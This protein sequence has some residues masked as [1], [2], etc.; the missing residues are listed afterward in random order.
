MRLREGGSQTDLDIVSLFDLKNWLKRQLYSPL[1]F[2]MMLLMKT[3]KRELTIIT[4]ILIALVVGACRSAP[5]TP[6]TVPTLT[7]INPTSTALPI[8]SATT[9]P[10]ATDTATPTSSLPISS[11][12]DG[13]RMAYIFD[14]NLYFQD[15]SKPPVQL[16]DSRE[17]RQPI[18]FSEDG[19]RVFFTRGRGEIYSI[20][21]DGSQEQALVTNDVL[22]TFGADYYDETTTP[23]DPVL[24]P[25]THLLLFRTCSVSVQSTILHHDDVF[26][27]DADTNKVK[28]IFPREQGGRFYVS[29]DGSMIAIDKLNSIDILGIDGRVIRS[30]VATYPQSEL[31]SMGARVYWVSDSK[32][33]I[34]LLPSKTFVDTFP[35]PTYTVWR[36]S[37][38]THTSVQIQLDPTPMNLGEIWVSPDGNWIAYF[39]FFEGFFLGNLQDGSTQ[40]YPQAHRYGNPLGWS[41]D[42]VHFIYEMPDP[43]GT[44]TGLGLASINAPPVF[45]GRGGFFIGW[46]DASRYLYIANTYGYAIGEIGKELIAILVG[47]TQPFIRPDFGTLIFKFQP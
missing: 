18:S 42:S 15:G 44:D 36:Y 7:A 27:V 24:V 11:A 6:T 19:K 17:D 21:V 46:L 22:L 16:T 47:S 23:C 12:P 3:P 28:L 31:I 14:G 8:P 35:P 26:I 40:A 20:N 45:L 33:L 9:T 2:A 37:L 4:M 32:E 29:S 25:H 30:K 1:E 10:P 41:P 43:S 5:S 38:D 13:L 39:N 34:M